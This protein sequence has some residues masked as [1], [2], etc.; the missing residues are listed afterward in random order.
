MLYQRYNDADLVEAQPTISLEATFL[1][2]NW[3]QIGAYSALGFSS[4]ASLDWVSFAGPVDSKPKRPVCPIPDKLDVF[5]L[6]G[7]LEQVHSSMKSSRIPSARNWS[8]HQGAGA[9]PLCSGKLTGSKPIFG[10]SRKS[11]SN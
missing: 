8:K 10:P 11:G 7:I 2:R 4:S 1:K 9:G 6:L 3:Y 5:V